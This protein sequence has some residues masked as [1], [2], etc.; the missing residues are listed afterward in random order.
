MGI[1][2]GMDIYDDIMG[3]NIINISAKSGEEAD[4]RGEMLQQ[5]TEPVYCHDDDDGDDDDGDDDD[6]DDIYI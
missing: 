6:D 3:G 4:N 2:F 1:V 5:R